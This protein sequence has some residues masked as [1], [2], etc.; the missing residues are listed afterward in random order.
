MYGTI[1]PGVKDGPGPLEQVT[2]EDYVHYFSSMEQ[3]GHASYRLVP[4]GREGRK[5]TTK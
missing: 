3:M 2:P 1:F 4:I 5:R